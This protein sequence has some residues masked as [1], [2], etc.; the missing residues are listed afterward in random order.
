MRLFVTRSQ[1]NSSTIELCESNFHYLSRVIRIRVKEKLTIIVDETKHMDVEFLGFIDNR[2]QYKLLN[3][4]TITDKSLKIS[5]IQSIPKQNKFMDV[6]DHVTQA[7]VAEIFPVYTTRTVVDWNKSKEET[8]LKKWTQ[9]ALAASSQSNQNRV[10]KIH[11]IIKLNQC[12]TNIDFKQFD[13]CIVAYE[14]EQTQTLHDLV[15][16]YPKV[17]SVCVLIG[18]EGGITSSEVE[19]IKS[20]GFKSISMGN[21][22]FRTEIAA[23]VCIA[24][25]LYCYDIRMNNK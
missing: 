13:L 20:F 8:H 17:N 22:I 19:D 11:P 21:S 4:F 24:Q 18:P 6:I 2:F 23:L 15:A 10:P 12:L 16:C 1:I 5:L 9:R 25:L 7:G 14:E 3:E